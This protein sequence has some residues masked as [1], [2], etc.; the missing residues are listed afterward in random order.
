MFELI[1][2]DGSGSLSP[3]E[4]KEGLRS[5][6]IILNQKD[7]NNMFCIFDSDKSGSIQ[8]N[9]MKETLET[10]DKLRNQINNDEIVS[11]ASRIKD[12]DDDNPYS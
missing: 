12:V 9:E 10:Y 3:A 11:E 8:L 4:L 1:D 7:L 5:L 2:T 6:K